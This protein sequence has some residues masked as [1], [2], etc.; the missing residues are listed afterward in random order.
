MDVRRNRFALADNARLLA[1][2]SGL[3]H[4]RNLNRPGIR[5][6]R[7]DEGMLDDVVYCRGRDN[8]C[9]RI[10]FDVGVDD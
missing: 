5:Y 8:V 2:K 7:I 4:R 1:R 10:S 6:T 9:A 3:D